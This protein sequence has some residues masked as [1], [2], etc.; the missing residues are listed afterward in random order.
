LMALTAMVIADELFDAQNAVSNDNPQSSE[1]FAE[2]LTNALQKQEAEY[3]KQVDA[4]TAT[5]QKLSE[6]LK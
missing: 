4:L 6:S 2:K 1:D 3:A 5:V